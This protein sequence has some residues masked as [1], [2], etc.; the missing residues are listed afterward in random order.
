MEI[1]ERATKEEVDIATRVLLKKLQAIKTESRLEALIL[2][3]IYVYLGPNII[4]DCDR[5]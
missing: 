2:N 1:T 3:G 5:K 4:P